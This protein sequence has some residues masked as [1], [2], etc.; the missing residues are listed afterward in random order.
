MDKGLCLLLHYYIEKV[1][2]DFAVW[3]KF[4]QI[5]GNGQ[6]FRHIELSNSIIRYIS[7]M[8]TSIP[9]AGQHS[10]LEGH[11]KAVGLVEQLAV[12]LFAVSISYF[13][14]IICSRSEDM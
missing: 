5:E 12:S 9:G 4:C 2:A 1:L 11:H 8:Y 6:K 7:Y 13:E 10:H 14:F 3:S